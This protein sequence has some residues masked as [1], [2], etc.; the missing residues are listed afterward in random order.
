MKATMVRR[1]MPLVVLLF[2]CG[3][4]TGPGDVGDGEFE[5]TITGEVDRTVSGDAFYVVGEDA[6][7]E[8][9]SIVLSADEEGF[10]LSRAGMTVPS[11][12][13]YNITTGI[14]AGPNDFFLSGFFR[15]GASF[16]HLCESGSIVDGSGPVFGTVTITDSGQDLVGTFTATVGCL[17]YESGAVVDATVT[18]AFDAK[19]LEAA[20][21]Q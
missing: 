6:G 14:D 3:D 2:G 5:F 19:E 8:S 9:I 16:S 12:G 17:N 10:I 1:L 13:T 4:G 11:A 18:G 7:E 20:D 15:E 21:V